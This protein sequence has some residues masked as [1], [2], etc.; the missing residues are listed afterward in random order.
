MTRP[1]AYSGRESYVRW[2][3]LMACHMCTE[4]PLIRRA[5]MRNTLLAVEAE[6]HCMRDEMRFIG[7]GILVCRCGVVSDVR[8]FRP[9]KHRL[10]GARDCPRKV[11]CSRTGNSHYTPKQPGTAHILPSARTFH[12]PCKRVRGYS[13]VQAKT[14]HVSGL[15]AHSYHRGFHLHIVPH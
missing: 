1:Q 5:L 15:Q 8:L 3:G 7:A 4:E 13:R 6:R 12:A 11:S 10:W 14:T 2:T 9:A